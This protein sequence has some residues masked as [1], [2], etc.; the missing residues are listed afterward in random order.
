MRHVTSK[1]YEVA[2]NWKVYVDNYL[3]GY[4]IP[5][6]HPALNRE[7]DYGQYRVEPRG[8]Y[9]LQHAP[10]RPLAPRGSDDGADAGGAGERRYVPREGDDDA[11]YYWLFPNVMLNLYMGQ[12][13]TNVVLPLGHA[14][15][16]VCFDW[17]AD[18]AAG[19][20]TKDPGWQSRLAFSDVIQDEDADICAA[21]QRNL[22]SRSYSRGRYSVT[23]E[24]GLHQFHAL[25][26]AH[27]ARA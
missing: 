14:R 22:A 15:T 7:L 25:L 8:L 11:Q 1:R 20:V 6:V 13:Q 5:L 26:C 21:V 16:A 17:F 23:R 9:S 24:P 2:C 18:E 27:L 10:M 3:E 4:H 12:L 19:D